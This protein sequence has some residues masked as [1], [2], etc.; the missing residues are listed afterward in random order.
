MMTRS[1]Y[2]K[3]LVTC[4]MCERQSTSREHVPPKCFF[5]GNSD[6]SGN[7]GFRKDLITVPSC[8]EHNLVKS[9][10][11]EYV[12]SVITMH[13]E[14]NPVAQ[15]HF[16]DKVLRGL[17]RSPTRLIDLAHSTTPVIVSGKQSGVFRVNRERFD[18]SL[19]YM[20][21]GIYF[22]HF[23]AKAEGQSH[24]ISYSLF[25]ISSEKKHEVNA[26][27]AN[28]RMASD[29]EFV[30]LPRFGKNP[31]IFFYQ[32]FAHLSDSRVVI[33]MVFYEGFVVDVYFPAS[34]VLG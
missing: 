12:C 15:S 6:M 5:P 11:D 1:K 2:P 21:R 31:K 20:A 14:N 29:E 33:R 27:Y 7:N 4:Y 23:C 13:F 24:V 30:R 28:L 22:H 34:K 8:D 19:D 17:M 26:A 25:D 3:R 18:L 16:V 9:K 10:D 32:V